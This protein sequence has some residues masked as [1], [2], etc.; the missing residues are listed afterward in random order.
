[1]VERRENY[2]FD[3]YNEVR[4][5]FFSREG[6]MVKDMSMNGLNILST[7]QP[8]VGSAYLIN[9]RN[10]G[11]HQSFRIKVVRSEVFFPAAANEAVRANEIVFTSGAV[12][13][14]LNDHRRNFII[15]ALENHFKDLSA[16]RHG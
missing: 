9:L 6:L 3:V 5:S 2:R 10:N 16:P 12:F 4:G 14:E 1:M 15:A 11:L 13:F 7:F 8:K